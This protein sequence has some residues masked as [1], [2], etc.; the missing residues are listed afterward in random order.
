VILEK[1]TIF[2]CEIEVCYDVPMNIRLA[3]FDMG[4][5]LAQHSDCK[6]EKKILN[7]FGVYQYGSFSELDPGLVPL[8]EKMSED[9][10]TEDQ[11]WDTFS[12]LTGISIPGHE[13]SIWGKFFNPSI[14]EEVLTLIKRIKKTGTRVVLASNTEPAHQRIHNRRGDYALFDKVY[15]SCLLH[16]VKPH[17]EFFEK[18]LRNEKIEASDVFFTDDYQSNCDA[19]SA[20]GIVSYK[21]AGAQGLER[22]LIDLGVLKKQ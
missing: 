3:M 20:L 2:E 16:E 13:E 11:F 5:V 6:M 14:D 22:R 18:I 19:A 15:T 21:F 17:A 9:L 8:M 4:G 12:E 10:I 7:Y 1:N